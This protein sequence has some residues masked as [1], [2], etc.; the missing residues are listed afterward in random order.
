MA[1]VVALLAG[2]VA[3]NRGAFSASISDA[4]GYLAGA[5][6]LREGRVARPVPLDLVPAVRDSGA[7]LSP[8]G[9]RAGVTR[10]IEV[11]TYPLGYP[12]L[13]TAA[14]HAGGELAAYLVGPALLAVLVW[15]AFLVAE[16]AGGSVAG[17]IAAALLAV[18]PVALQNSVSAMSDVPAAACWAAAWY[19]ALRGTRGAAAAA[20]ALVALACMIR[21]NLMPLAVVPGVLVLGGG[22]R[23]GAGWAWGPAMVFAVTAAIGPIV[24]ASWQAVLYGSAFRPGYPGWELFFQASHIGRN[25]RT[26]PALYLQVFGWWPLAGLGLVLRPPVDPR[27]RIVAAA[28]GFIAINAA[29]Y[30]TYLP[31]DQWPFLRFFLPALT[32]LTVLFAAVLALA[33]EALTSRGWKAVAW[34]LPLAA[35]ASAWQ[36][37]AFTTGV[38]DEWRAQ[39]RVPLMGRYLQHTLPPNAVVITYYHGGSVAYYTG[40]RTLSLESFPPASLDA[41]VRTLERNGAVPIFLVDESLEETAFKSVFRGSEYGALDWAPRAEF[42][43]QAR[44]R[45]F[46]ASDRARFR[47]G[48]RWP[49]DVL[50]P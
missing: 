16:A 45:S 2:A 48:E 17:L 26:Y 27:W 3:V 13:M 35:A 15:C 24:T 29:L 32:A 50:R 36:G 4:S 22:L 11:P 19:F 21:P 6:L 38:L 8:L 41:L 25:L 23:R 30:A 46:V 9:F 37:R 14:M 49:V 1:L 42:I 31:Y 10:G 40:R 20:G 28:V 43:D 47:A 44:I 18:N 34:L 33:M 7:T 39:Q 12:M 5:Q